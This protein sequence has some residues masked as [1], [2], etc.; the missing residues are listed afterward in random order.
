MTLGL[1]PNESPLVLD[2]D[3]S[4]VRVFLSDH[5]LLTMQP[6]N[7]EIN[8][9]PDPELSYRWS[10]GFESLGDEL[11]TLLTDAANESF[12]LGWPRESAALAF[13]PFV[14]AYVESYC[15]RKN[16]LNRAVSEHRGRP[17]LISGIPSAGWVTPGTSKAFTV[18]ARVSTTFNR[19]L[20]SMI[21][22]DLGIPVSIP[23]DQSM[24][25]SEPEVSSGASPRR[26]TVRLGLPSCREASSCTHV[27][28]SSNLFGRM[29]G[30]V[31]W[32][33]ARGGL[34]ADPP[35]GLARKAVSVD[36]SPRARLFDQIN[37]DGLVGDLWRRLQILLP[38]SLLEGLPEA[39]DRARLRSTPRAFVGPI[40]STDRE[41]VQLAVYAEQGTRIYLC[42]HGGFYG[43]TVPKHS[44]IHER[45][46]STEFLTWGWIDGNHSRPLPAP[47]LS[48]GIGRTMFG[49][50]RRRSKR[51]LDRILWVTQDQWPLDYRL[52]PVSTGVD[53]YVN[54]CRTFVA[55]LDGATTRRIL[56]RYRS[57]KYGIGNPTQRQ[58]QRAALAGLAAAPSLAI[59]VLL[60]RA[61]LVVIDRA[62]TT[63]FL[64]CLSR[65]IPVIVF[66]PDS[67][68]YVRAGVRHVYSALAAVD[69]IH[70][71]PQRAAQTVMA[72]NGDARSWWLEPKRQR[73]VQLAST[74]LA[75]TGPAYFSTWISFLRQVREPLIAARQE[76]HGD[77]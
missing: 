23:E 55:A 14:R 57:A 22:T 4:G 25:G 6:E 73:A 48:R 56:V 31:L 8:L 64:E 44:E 11:I 52:P 24:A 70:T 37:P 69:I 62:F 49:H 13:G 7:R 45:A 40:P 29:H 16:I 1:G 2:D 27:H 26:S 53:K 51:A 50:L 39:V 43:E 32:V 47:R 65:D 19:Q 74:T 38:A 5:W 60:A 72:I 34:Y 17:R 54:S 68:P 59:D 28:C 75:R 61:D 71:S 42:Q 58:P 12:D 10:K 9:Q 3:R 67:L 46:A 77:A 36:P 76:T 41:H 15:V 66:D 63:T 33:L 30:L 20:F 35:S 21:A 18:T